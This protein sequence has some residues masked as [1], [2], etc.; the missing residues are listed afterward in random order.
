MIFAIPLILIGAYVYPYI[1][2]YEHSWCAI[3]IG[4]GID[5]PGCGMVSSI[6]A[7][8][9]GNFAESFHYHPLGAFLVLGLILLWIKSIVGL[10]LGKWQI[11]ASKLFVVVLFVEWIVRLVV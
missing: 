1:P 3:K 6:S 5:C 8:L 2:G 10:N 9:H 11:V 4:A 7:F